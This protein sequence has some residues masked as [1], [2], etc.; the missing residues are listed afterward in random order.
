MFLIYLIKA[1][2]SKIAEQV[3]PNHGTS[4]HD[5][6]TE[7]GKLLDVAITNQGDIA[8]RSADLHATTD[9]THDTLAEMVRR[10]SHRL[11]AHAASPE[12]DRR[13]PGSDR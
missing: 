8:D 2:T 4:M 7:Q 1:E 11:D 10:V 12:H 9:A 13:G 5:L 6:I 3:Q